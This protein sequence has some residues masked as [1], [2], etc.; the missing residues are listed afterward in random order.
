MGLCIRLLH[1]CGKPNH[2]EENEKVYV[3]SAKEYGG[4][5]I[6]LAA[7][8]DISLFPDKKVIEIHILSNCRM[9][10]SMDIN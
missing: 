10:L 9:N 4:L 5:M 7:L 2:S 1:L 3:H 8:R 6:C